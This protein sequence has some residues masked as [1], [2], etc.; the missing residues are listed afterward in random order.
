MM[1][2]NSVPKLSGLLLGSFKDVIVGTKSR[3]MLCAS[4][5][6]AENVKS[7]DKHDENLSL[8]KVAENRGWREAERRGDGV[9]AT[10]FCNPSTL[11][12]APMEVEWL[13][14]ESSCA[15]FSTLEATTSSQ[16]KRMMVEGA[17]ELFAVGRRS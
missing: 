2:E 1:E 16:S 6:L 15:D 8:S 9:L 3:F 11:V 4:S 5:I 17:E 13:P 7:R 10:K 12:S 14:F